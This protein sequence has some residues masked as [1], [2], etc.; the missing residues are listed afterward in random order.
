MYQGLPACGKTTD[1]KEKQAEDGNIVRVNKDDL[2]DMLHA[3]GW[4]GPNEKQILRIRDFI[5]TDA[6]A[7]GHDVIVDDTNF[8][9]KHGKRLKELAEGYGAMF[10]VKFFD[11]PVE[12]CI[13]RDAKR[14]NS[15]G[16]KTIMEMY[17]QYLAPKRPVIEYDPKLPDCI[18]VDVDGTLSS[19]EGVR[20]PFE[21]EKSLKDKPQEDIVKLVRAWRMWEA[22]DER[23]RIF[24]VTGAE[25][26][27]RGIRTQWL[28]DNLVPHHEMF[29]RPTGDFRPDYEIK[30]ELYYRHI[31]GRYNVAF[32]LDDRQQV[33]DMWRDL[34]LRVLQVAEGDF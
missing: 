24:I 31:A 11:V 12:K 34:G 28:K 10:V 16:R 3:G 22:E 29:M 2:R 9:P 14:H 8:H 19:S 5:I 23:S 26:K 25:E 27:Y 4:S 1:A 7:N 30:N 17:K 15:V 13:K 33:V 18:L 32:V 20:G 6:L 21:F